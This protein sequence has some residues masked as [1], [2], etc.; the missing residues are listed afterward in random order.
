MTENE[1][2]NLLRVSTRSCSEF[3]K[4]YIT[5]KLPEDFKY[6]VVLNVSND[7]PAL[8]QFDIYPEDSGKKAELIDEKEVIKLLYRNGKIPVWIDISVE[9]VHQ[10]KTII[11]LLC[12]GRYSDKS[13]DYYYNHHDTVSVFGIKGPVFPTGYVEGEKFRLNNKYK[14]SLLRWLKVMFNKND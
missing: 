5:N 8:T 12:A 10:N 14:K 1:F 11:H 13:E 7:D 6:S 3:A 2:L 4:N 9:C